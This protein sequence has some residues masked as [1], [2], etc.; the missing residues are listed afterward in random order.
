VW[1]APVEGRR[2]LNF[3]A[4][5]QYG[6]SSKGI[7]YETQQAARASAPVAGTVLLAGDFRSYG[8][9]V[10]LDTCGFDVLLA[11]L[12]SLSVRGGDV[13]DAAGELGRMHGDVTRGLPVLYFEIRS[14]GRP[15]D[16]SSFLK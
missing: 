6:A 8:K 13:V 4:R 2:V 14:A 7:V 9:L 11:G 5:T 1:G 15:V 16:P 3:A 10:V 12:N